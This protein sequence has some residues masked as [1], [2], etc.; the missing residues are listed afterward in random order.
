MNIIGFSH[1]Y[2]KLHGQSYGTLLAVQKVTVDENFPSDGIWWD[3]LY[4]TA[5]GHSL[6]HF[7]MP[8]GDYLQLVFLGNK[9]IPFTTYRLCPRHYK[10][11][12]GV[13]CHAYTKGVPYTDLIGQSFAFKFKGKRLPANLVKEV[14]KNKGKH[15][16][17]FD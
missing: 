1:K 17:I 9:H 14:E 4:E 13:G 11:F 5:R 3:T 12:R 6:R 15:M 2:V 8:Y 7:H 10:P 16:S